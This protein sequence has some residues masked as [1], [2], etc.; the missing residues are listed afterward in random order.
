MKRG[1]SPSE[2]FGNFRAGSYQ[3]VLNF[4]LRAALILLILGALLSIMGV[5]E[6]VVTMGVGVLLLSPLISLLA[7]AF[8][9]VKKDRD[10]FF[11]TLLILTLLLVNIVL[12]R[13]GL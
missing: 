13:L 10:S 2:N 4:L 1:F 12:L 11:L 7:L 3:R 9:L 6:L 5:T 8:D